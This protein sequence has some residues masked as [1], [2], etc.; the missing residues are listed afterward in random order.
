MVTERMDMATWAAS[1]S[2]MPA[3]ARSGVISNGPPTVWAMESRPAA[4]SMGMAPSSSASR[5]R[6]PST[7]S[8]SVRVGW[9][10]AP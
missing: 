6:C 1:T 5:L 8:A 4:A 9:S 3:A 7:T 2:T 10:P